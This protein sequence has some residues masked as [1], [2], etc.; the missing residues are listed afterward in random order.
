L[1]SSAGALTACLLAR[2]I[3]HQWSLY[4][5]FGGALAG[6]SKFFILL[7][8][9]YSKYSKFCILVMISSFVFNILINS[10]KLLSAKFS[11]FLSG[12]VCTSSGLDIYLSWGSLI[13]GFSGGLF[14]LLFRNLMLKAK[15]NDPG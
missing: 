14:Y 11:I 4:R 1:S 5:L 12:L 9:F 10:D 6:Q 7:F 2:I 3:T 15:V 8:C 13:L